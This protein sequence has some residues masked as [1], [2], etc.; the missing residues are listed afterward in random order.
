MENRGAY[1]RKNV[2]N[3]QRPMST[4]PNALEE[5]DCNSN[6]GDTS[7][8][9]DHILDPTV[10]QAKTLGASAEPRKR[11]CQASWI[12]IPPPSAKRHSVASPARK[13]RRISG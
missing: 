6:S 12:P 10:A 3:G 4:E 9:D 11:S 8:S 5:L 13:R 1:R 7:D 2:Q